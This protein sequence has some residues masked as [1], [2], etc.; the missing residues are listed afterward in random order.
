VGLLTVLVPGMTCR[1]CVRK[2]TAALRDVPGVMAVLAD[3]ATTTVVLHGGPDG[4]RVLAALESAG[5]PGVMLPAPGSGPDDG[6][7]RA[8]RPAPRAPAPDG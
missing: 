6:A 7:S 8:D 2:V 5:F 3:T 1:H 4:E